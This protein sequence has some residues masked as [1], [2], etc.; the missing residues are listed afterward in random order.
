M[1]RRTKTVCAEIPGL[2]PSLWKAYT[3]RRNGGRCLSREARD[4]KDVA[5]RALLPSRPRS[6]LAG[7]VR[8]SI[9]L[10]AKGRRRWDIEN[11]VK[12]LSDLLTEMCF[13]G[14]DSQVWDLR[15]RREIAP[16]DAT[17]IEITP[18]GEEV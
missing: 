14:D 2:P 8:L 18:I 9:T 7:I 17:K 1:A 11:R 6:P 13:W 10:K 4:W 12:V 16:S 3:M 5:A 15:V